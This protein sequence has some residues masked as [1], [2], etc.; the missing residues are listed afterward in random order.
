[1]FRSASRAASLALLAL[2][3]AL[4][5]GQGC[6]A[7]ASTPEA[8]AAA[9]VLDQKRSPALRSLDAQRN[10][11]AVLALARV[12]PGERVLDVLASPGY[13]T[14]MLASAVGAAGH[15]DAY[16][17]PQFVQSPQARQDW[18][19]RISRYRNVRQVLA[20]LHT[21]EPPESTY[22]LILLHLAFHETYWES[23]RFG[24]VRMEPDRF[25][26]S[27]IHALRDGGRIVVVDHAAEAGAD[28]RESV[29]RYHRIDP[30]EVIRAF[31][32]AGLSLVRR[33][34]ALANAG[35]DRTKSVFAPEVRGRTDRFAFVFART[36][37]EGPM[38]H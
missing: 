13:Y 18:T 14:E 22:D 23:P 35:D 33:S 28:P 21:F 34:D 11:A 16:D 31:R 4:A 26:R 38:P 37:D 6:G 12:G 15:V 27:L 3:L 1:M 29:D 2:L 17:P 9:S 10:P 20:P 36:A 5:V 8:V 25:A 30:A 32:A 24:L 7:P 19:A